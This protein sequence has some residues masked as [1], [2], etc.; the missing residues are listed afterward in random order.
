[1]K[2]RR[3]GGN[4][5]SRL[6]EVNWV[7]IT[8]STEIS[9][10]SARGLCAPS[11]ASS[12]PISSAV[13]I[14]LSVCAG[15][16]LS[17][18]L[19]G[20]ARSALRL[21]GR[22]ATSLAAS[23]ADLL[24]STAWASLEIE[25][26]TLPVFAIV[27]EANQPLPPATFY[28]DAAAA[29]EALGLARA[30]NPGLELDTTPLGLGTAYR[31]QAEG[32]GAIVPARADLSAAGVP[33]DVPAEGSEV[34]LFTCAELQSTRVDGTA[35]VPLF[36]SEADAQAAV[37]EATA[38]GAPAEPLQV[39][40]LSLKWGIEQFC[41]VPDSPFFRFIPPSRSVALIRSLSGL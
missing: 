22:A 2:C 21:P 28:V 16:A 31:A 29:E 5:G 20:P 14:M 4:V 15:L 3:L 13:A 10:I 27:D 24:A 7:Q 11:R 23:D 40:C 33:A 32:S 18:A 1:M 25:L 19:P 35:T 39:Q 30:A 36:L 12:S 6:L 8:I 38:A 37:A 34:P 9:V 41:L 17:F 26:D